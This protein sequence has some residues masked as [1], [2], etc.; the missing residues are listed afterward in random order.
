MTFPDEMRDQWIQEEWSYR[1]G[2]PPA[3]SICGE[4]T[5]FSQGRLRHATPAIPKM[6][7]Q[8]GTDAYYDEQSAWGRRMGEFTLR[9]GTHAAEVK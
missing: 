8:F 4:P 5:Q 3:C 6:S 9:T 1:N 2:E 7:A